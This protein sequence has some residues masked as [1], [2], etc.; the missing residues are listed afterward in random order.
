MRNAGSTLTN[1]LRISPLRALRASRAYA[2]AAAPKAALPLPTHAKYDPEL[3][4]QLAGLDYPLLST[5]SRQLRKP[6]G[7]WD[8]QERVNF[9]EPVSRPLYAFPRR[10]SLCF[11]PFPPRS[12]PFVTL[13]LPT[14]SPL[15][16][17]CIRCPKTKTSSQCG[18][19]TSTASPP[20]PPSPS[21]SPPLL[22]SPSLLEA[23]TSFKLP[24][25][26]YRARTL[27][28]D[29]SR[30]SPERAILS[31]RSVAYP[32]SAWRLADLCFVSGQDH[33]GERDRRVVMSIQY[34]HEIDQFPVTTA[35]ERT[36]AIR[37]I[38]PTILRS[39]TTN[40]P[41]RTASQISNRISIP[42]IPAVHAVLRSSSSRDLEVV[43]GSDSESRRVDRDNA[44]GKLGT[45]SS[46]AVEADPLLPRSQTARLRSMLTLKCTKE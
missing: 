7:Y 30:L 13:L 6:T 10:N 24:R 31:T 18:P 15:C 17:D 5:A 33:G 1:M 21:S 36:F 41:Y 29:S 11:S 16:R 34:F 14:I 20:S 42:D 43:V 2:T 9:D 44:E 32:T 19:P 35:H 22:S 12:R 27:T 37:R 8:S 40:L 4:P 26:D 45:D 25:L 46:S 3:D 39:S 28:T 38:M 23:S